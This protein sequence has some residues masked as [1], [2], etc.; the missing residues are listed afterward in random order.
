MLRISP[1]IQTII[2]NFSLSF[3]DILIYAVKTTKYLEIEIDHQLNFPPKT[4]KL[5]KK[6]IPKRWCPHQIK[7]LLTQISSFCYLLWDSFSHLLYGII[8]WGSTY[9]TYLNKLQ[10]IQN[11][12]ISDAGWH[13]HVTP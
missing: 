4:Q 6:A 8:I 10:T 13:V 3:G 9:S 5:Q 11:K 7:T 2:P 1:K 12:A